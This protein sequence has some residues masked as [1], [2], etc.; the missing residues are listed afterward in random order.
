MNYVLFVF[1]FFFVIIRFYLRRNLCVYADTAYFFRY[2]VFANKGAEKDKDIFYISG[3]RVPMIYYYWGLLWFA[4]FLKIKLSSIEQISHCLLIILQSLI[5]YWGS[6][7]F[8]EQG[9]IL[10]VV[11]FLLFF[12]PPK[13]FSYSGNNEILNSFF[14]LFILFVWFRFNSIFLETQI[15]MLSFIVLV[16]WLLFSFKFLHALKIPLYFF[17]FGG[18]IYYWV[19]GVLLGGVLYLLPHIRYGSIFNTIKV[20][21]SYK[22]TNE[23]NRMRFS[24]LHKEFLCQHFPGFLSLV[25]LYFYPPNVAYWIILFFIADLFIIF[26]QNNCYP[27]HGI[28]LYKYYAFSM[29]FLPIEFVFI[30]LA[31]FLVF[32]FRN[33]LL[34]PKALKRLDEMCICQNQ[35]GEDLKKLK[36]INPNLSVLTFGHFVLLHFIS[37]VKEYIEELYSYHFVQD[38][39]QFNLLFSGWRDALIRKLISSPPDYVYVYLDACHFYS[40][41]N[42]ERLTGTRYSYCNSYLKDKILVYSKLENDSDI[43]VTDDSLEL[44]SKTNNIE[45]NYKVLKANIPVGLHEVVV[46]DELENSPLVALVEEAITVDEF[47]E[48]QTLKIK[49]QY[50]LATNR[51]QNEILDLMH[52]KKAEGT[53]ITKLL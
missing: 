48:L 50:Y 9:S 24:P 44:L 13:T 22:S 31:Y 17:L 26:L 29:I 8:T 36:L 37:G 25:G 46:V 33:K 15:L 23:N 41:K 30:L 11:C 21:R 7:F 35:M 2:S 52:A 49:T 27:Y 16:S 5:L 45:E 43:D 20:L 4:K 40:I 18:D 10:A 47:L 51:N 42:I 6:T 3:S 32:E 14:D 1:L 12:T 39:E 19:L 53:I 34:F 28:P 38:L